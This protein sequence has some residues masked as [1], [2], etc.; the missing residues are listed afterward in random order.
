M[1]PW[2]NFLLMRRRSHWQK[3]VWYNEQCPVESCRLIVSIAPRKP[4]STAPTYMRPTSDLSILRVSE[5]S[6]KLT[7]MTLPVT[8][9]VM[10]AGPTYVYDICV[11][12]R[13]ELILVL[14]LIA[15]TRK[16]STAK[17]CLFKFT[18]Q[19][20]KHPCW[21]ISE[22]QRSS[23]LVKSLLRHRWWVWC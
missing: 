20:K 14:Q 3:L 22:S 21:N 18:G 8:S 10:C 13:N 6:V 5:R 23:G 17:E 4:C 9:S 19:N 2:H 11:H 7:R 1:Y 16:M 15:E 12:W